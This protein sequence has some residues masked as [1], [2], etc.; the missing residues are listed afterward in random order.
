VQNFG[1]TRSNSPEK[2]PQLLHLLNSLLHT[3]KIMVFI[4][5]LIINTYYNGTHTIH[6]M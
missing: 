5:R 2:I 3:A 6:S 1:N 4:T